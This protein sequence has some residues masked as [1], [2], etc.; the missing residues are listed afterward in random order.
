MWQHIFS[1]SVMLTVWR[2]EHVLV[3]IKL[4][5]SKCTVKQWNLISASR[6]LFNK[7]SITMHG[8][9]NVK[10]QSC[11]FSRIRIKS[12][13]LSDPYLFLEVLQVCDKV[14]VLSPDYPHELSIPPYWSSEDTISLRVKRKRVEETPRM[15]R[16]YS[17]W[18][19]YFGSLN[20][21]QEEGARQPLFPS[22][23]PSDWVGSDL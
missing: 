2:R 17:V 13:T 5:E 20:L 11:C 10:I 3:W 1:M 22:F 14:K 9:V 23:S 19:N 21:L 18:L 12:E 7:K 4:S 6:W 16:R 8:N 15:M